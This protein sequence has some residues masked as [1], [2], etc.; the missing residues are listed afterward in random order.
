MNL[1]VSI[2]TSVDGLD[3]GVAA[4]LDNFRDEHVPLRLSLA[5]VAAAVVLF[6]LLLG[7]GAVAWVRLV[8]LRRIVRSPSSPAAFAKAFDGIDK[9]LARSIVGAAWAA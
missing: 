5:I 7:W 1:L 3:P 8:R 2:A 9:A 6:V 4:F